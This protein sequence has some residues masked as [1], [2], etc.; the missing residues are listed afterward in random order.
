[1]AKF[2]KVTFD[3]IPTW[4]VYGLEYGVSEDGSLTEEDSK[5]IE[6][7]LE[8]NNLHGYVMEV[9]WDSEGFSHY[10]AFGLACNT[11]EADFYLEQAE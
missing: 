5:Q 2:K 7:F 4:A 9:N 6:D 8:A 1:M 10:P 11:V 3:N